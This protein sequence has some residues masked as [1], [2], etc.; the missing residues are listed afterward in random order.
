MRD[1]APGIP[2]G[3]ARQTVADKRHKARVRREMKLGTLLFFVVLGCLFGVGVFYSIRTSIVP[4][5]SPPSEF[6][7]TRTGSI[8]FSSEDGL[9]CRQAKFDN[10][11]G[12]ITRSK[13]VACPD[14]A[15]AESAGNESVNLNDR[16]S[17]I[18]DAFRKK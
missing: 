3:T 16:M 11:T 6:T 8:L 15:A 13:A 10:A 18:R 12:M 14:A 7:K 5:E 1:A 9:R 17:S 4:R 2:V